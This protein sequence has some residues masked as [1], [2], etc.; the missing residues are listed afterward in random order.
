MSGKNILVINAG[1][2]STKVG[3]FV[4]TEEIYTENLEH[5]SEHLS[6]YGSVEDQLSFRQELVCK[7]VEEKVHNLSQ[8]DAIVA[9]GGLIYPVAGGTY[10]IGELMVEHLKQA[11]QG[12]HP[13][14]L[15]GLI[16]YDLATKYN[17]PAYTVDPVVVDELN[18]VARISG[19][20]EIERVSK[21][22]ALNSKA[23]ARKVAVE[24]G[25]EY[26]DLNIITVH[27]GSGISVNPHEK[28]KMID[29][30]NAVSGGPF[31]PERAGGLP[32]EEL[33]NLCFSGKYSHKEMIT[34]LYREGGIYSYLGTKD[35]REVV[36]KAQA[37]DE[38]AELI[39]EAMIYQ[40][41]KE[42]G[43]MATVL[44]GNVDV[45][46]ITG[47]MAHSA[48]VL[49]RLFERIE[50]IGPVVVLPGERELWALAWG[51]NRVLTGQEQAKVYTPD[52]S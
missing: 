37:G 45:V 44:K 2:S 5:S 51:A 42:I 16:A 1:G 29:V 40:T 27:L 26:S 32:S 30:S 35:I 13:S 3:I 4:G 41:A 47:G 49:K 19:L 11:V 20:K 48:E 6:K 33:I 28:G 50:W 15:G 34:K 39:L 9:R 12:S 36:A 22:H 23:M 25:K 38:Q 17:I 10:E 14:N 21:S 24:M 31:A 7:W 18:P 46:V 52:R 8:L 43:G